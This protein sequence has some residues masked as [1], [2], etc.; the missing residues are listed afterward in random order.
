MRNFLF[1]I[2][3]IP[4]VAGVIVFGNSALTD[5]EQLRIDYRAYEDVI[6]STDDLSML[7]KAEAAQNIQRINLFA[8]GVWALLS[9]ILAA[10][11]LH[12]WLSHSKS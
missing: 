6:R 5:W 12:G 9:S 7:F 2:V 10:I 11:G 1:L 8:D 3:I 4:G